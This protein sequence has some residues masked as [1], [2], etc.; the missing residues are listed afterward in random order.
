MVLAYLEDL[1]KNNNRD[2][3]NTNKSRYVA[4]KEE[5]ELFVNNLIPEIREIDNSIG[6]VTAKDCVFRIYRDVRFSTN[7]EPY[8][9]NMGAYISRDGKKGK[10]AGYYIHIEPDNNSFIAAGIHMPDADTLK[11]IRI[12]I[13]ENTDEMKKIINDSKFKNIFPEIYGE[14]LKTAPKG[15]PKEFK[16]IEL[17]KFKSYAIVHKLD[18]KFV[19]NETNLKDSLIDLYKIAHPFNTFINRVIENISENV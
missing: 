2:W 13:M 9:T 16:D 12:E 7:K 14:K 18:D 8:K 5:F 11:E 3:F 4:A 17:L 19:K 6:V 10:F 15:F 1:K